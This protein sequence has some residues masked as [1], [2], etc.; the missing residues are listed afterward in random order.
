MALKDKI[1]EDLKSAMKSGDKLRLETV[2]SIRALILEFEKS[3][4]GRDISSEDEIK[5]L[6]TAVKKRKDAMEQYRNANREDLASKEE[7]E[8]NIIMEYLPKQLSEEEIYEE[9]KKTAQEI[10]AK[11]KS[12]FGKLMPVVA[13]NLKGKAEGKVIKGLVEKYLGNNWIYLI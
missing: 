6:S 4:A 8:M 1:N 11:E 7:A 2:R 10:G 5:M 3:G 9:I 13:K 12:D